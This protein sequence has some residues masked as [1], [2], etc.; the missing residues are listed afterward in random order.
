MGI[1]ASCGRGVIID[2][3]G[4]TAVH[5]A[6]IP[7]HQ[8]LGVIGATHVRAGADTPAAARARTRTGTTA[9]ATAAALR[10]LFRKDSAAWVSLL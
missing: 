3:I 4:D 9:T 8:L 7:P 5:V 2:I 6:G 10:L 1:I